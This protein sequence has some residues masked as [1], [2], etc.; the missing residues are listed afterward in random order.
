MSST[1]VSI[2]DQAHDTEIESDKIYRFYAVTTDGKREEY[3][4][5]MTAM[6]ELIDKGVIVGMQPESAK[7]SVYDSLAKKPTKLVA[8]GRQWFHNVDTGIVWHDVPSKLIPTDAV[9]PNGWKV[10]ACG[11]VLSPQNVIVGSNTSKGCV[12]VDIPRQKVDGKG[13]KAKQEYVHRLVAFTFHPDTDLKKLVQ[14]IDKDG[15]NNSLD[16]LEFS[17]KRRIGKSG[18]SVKIHQT[19]LDG[20][21]V[22]PHDSIA[23]ANES[24]GLDREHKGIGAHMHPTNGKYVNG[25]K[26][27]M[28]KRVA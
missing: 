20:K 28:W 14:H 26:G 12:S 13:V 18:Q 10:S 3:T 5:V 27:F 25:F 4:D 19:D 24:I 23:D 11:K 7:N 15:F 6:K 22:A 9:H 17:D 21:F 2:D 1:S 8:H 16:N